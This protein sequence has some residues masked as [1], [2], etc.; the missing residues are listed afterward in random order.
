[1]KK[2]INIFAL[3]L[4]IGLISLPVTVQAQNLVKERFVDLDYVLEKDEAQN[5]TAEL[6][7]ISE[8]LQ[9]DIV[10]VL[11]DGALE[12]T[13][14]QKF[15]DDYF[16]NGGYGFGKNH[17]GALLLVD[18]TY[19]EW[20]ISTCG[21]GIKA[22]SDSE[23]DYIGE[24]IAPYLSEGEYEMAFITFAQLVEDEVSE[25]KDAE[26]LSFGEILV[27]IP[28]ALL[29]GGGLAFIPVAVMK[30]KMN[31]VK[32][33]QEASD[34]VRRDKVMITDSRDIF[35]YRTINRRLRPKENSSTHRSSSG[36]VH[37]GRG[38]KF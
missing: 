21:L 23:L 6:D 8:K 37:G 15:A 7:E 22:L 1:M 14:S 33:K 34:Y 35:L 20:Y 17:D 19:R 18:L 31:N 38:G 5:V 36:R 16:D 29:I 11:A 10:V 25:L 2:I 12:G 28:I 30:S 32:M 9:F 3:L 27:R 13:N 24:T 4:M 26:E